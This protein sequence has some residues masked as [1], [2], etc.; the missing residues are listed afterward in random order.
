VA[1]GESTEALPPGNVVGG[2]LDTRPI[3]I[4]ERDEHGVP[5]LRR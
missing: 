3:A 2:R 5:R 1:R 4:E